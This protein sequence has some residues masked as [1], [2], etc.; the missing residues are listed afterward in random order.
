MAA[1]SPLR[2]CDGTI[3][4]LLAEGHSSLR[5]IYTPLSMH[6]LQQPCTEDHFFLL[7]EKAWT[8]VVATAHMPIVV[9]VW[10]LS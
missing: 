3:N 9:K 7:W 5:R 8:S 4:F 10:V 2:T 1:V 6:V